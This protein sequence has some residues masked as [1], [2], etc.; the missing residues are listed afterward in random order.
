MKEFHIISSGVSI[1]T[2][3][4]KSG[5]LP[6]NIKVA[7]E[8]FWSALLDNP[9]EIAKF[10]DFLSQDPLS[11]SAELNTFLRV[12]KDKN[13][14]L[15]E[16][17]LFGTKTKS[18]EFCRRVIESFLKEKGYT[19]YSPFE[20]SGYFWEAKF[21]E[22]QA[23]DEFQ[24]G[25][26]ELL[27]RLIYLARK[28]KE[29]GYEIYFNPTGGLKAH[30]IVTALSAFLVD[31]TVYYMNEEFNQVIFMPKLFYLPKGK[32]KDV[33]KKLGSVTYL[34]NEDAREF[35]I[36]Y[37]SEIDRLSIYGLITIENEGIE[38]TIIRLTERGRL[39]Y[40]NME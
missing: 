8:D 15:I 21:D 20:I 6:Q 9:Y 12:V 18:N 25:I 16:V 4:Q 23:V 22:K 10:R 37:S 31:A 2:N 38:A 39:I 33:L 34:K 35:L 40:K 1:I 24:K 3:A 7:D 5:I 17:Y 27:D 36:N 11:H 13:P 29:E 28:K 19:L 26:S 30:V 14:Q 32:E